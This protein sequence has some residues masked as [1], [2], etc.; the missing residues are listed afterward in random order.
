MCNSFYGQDILDTPYLE[1]V[2]VG[3]CPGGGG[4]DV[5][6]VTG[7]VAPLAGQVPLVC[8]PA[9]KVVDRVADHF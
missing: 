4:P 2:D 6:D 3:G 7:H 9:H 8:I 5:L 1:F